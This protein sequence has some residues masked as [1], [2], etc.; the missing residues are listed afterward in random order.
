MTGQYGGVPAAASFLRKNHA[1]SVKRAKEAVQPRIDGSKLIEIVITY[2]DPSDS[3]QLLDAMRSHLQNYY[4]FVLM[5]T[6]IPDNPAG[7]HDYINSTDIYAMNGLVE[8]NWTPLT[9]TL[10]DLRDRL[11]DLLF[12]DNEM[13]L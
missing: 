12:G 9:G 4:D 11:N 8:G 2:L 5:G 3:S 10:A 6:V 1:E 7:L 13:T